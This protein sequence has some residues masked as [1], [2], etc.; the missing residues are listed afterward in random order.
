MIFHE[1]GLPD[2]YLI[3]PEPLEDERGFFARIF[4]A[5]EFR[6]RNLNPNVAQCSISYN[7]EA[8]TLRGL[9]YQRPPYEE[10]RLVRC[11]RGRVFDVVVDIRRDSPSYLQWRGFELD[12]ENR[13]AVFIPEGLAHGFLTRAANVDM[14]YQM[15]VV[16][17]PAMTRGLRWDDPALNI[18]WPESPA[19][20]SSR[21]AAW[22]LIRDGRD[23]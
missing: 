9:H 14:L 13:I 8:G 16:F 21:D 23:G 12:A 15:S 20:I 3:E 19:C 1:T 22:P 6:R 17:E 2:C 4:D 5:D 18:A 7:R 11:L 10:A